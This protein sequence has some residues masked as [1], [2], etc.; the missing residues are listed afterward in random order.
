M[1]GFG[2]LGTAISRGDL[3]RRLLGRCV[4]ARKQ[5]CESTS[6]AALALIAFGQ[7]HVSRHEVLSW[8]SL[9]DARARVARVYLGHTSIG[10]QNRSM[11]MLSSSG[12]LLT[13]RRVHMMAVRTTTSPRWRCSLAAAAHDFTLPTSWKVTS[14]DAV[15]RDS[16][17]TR[18]FA[19]LLRKLWCDR[20]VH[21][22]SHSCMY[23]CNSWT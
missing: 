21:T 5:I 3:R 8:A 9:S 17:T 2:R 16:V 15:Y 20:P 1:T 14:T 11:S 7:R 19:E 22:H 13:R 10:W 6:A 12:R 23:E 4:I 18:S